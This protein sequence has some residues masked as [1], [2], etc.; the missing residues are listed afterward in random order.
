MQRFS[1][2]GNAGLIR[3]VGA[4]GGAS[5]LLSEDVAPPAAFRMSSDEL[6]ELILEAETIGPVSNEM[7][8]ELTGLD[9][10]GALRLLK[11]LVSEGMLRQTGDR[12]GT[13]YVSI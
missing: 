2:S 5:Y 11:R 9:R 4:R 7:V 13:R 10:K 8:R 12:R 3:Q 1:V 6:D